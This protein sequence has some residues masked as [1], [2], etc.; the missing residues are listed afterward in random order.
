MEEVRSLTHHEIEIGQGRFDD[1]LGTRYLPEVDGDAAE[2]IGCSPP[3]EADQHVGATCLDEIAI[4]RLELRG[5]TMG[6]PNIELL[7][8]DEYNVP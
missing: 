7:R 8:I 4:E 3:S 2:R 6:L 5:D 1:H